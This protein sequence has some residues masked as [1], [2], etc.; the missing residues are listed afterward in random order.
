MKTILFI[1]ARYPGYGG[2]E[3]ITTL[4]ANRLSNKF[5]IIICSIT[6]Q[7]EK[8]LL[9]KLDNK[10]LFLKFPNSSIKKS[11]VNIAYLNKLII[12]RSINYII[13][14]DSYFPSQYLL[15]GI[16]K[17]DSL[18][19]IVVEHSS[20]NGFDIQ[21]RINRKNCSVWDLYH[22]F[23]LWLY[24][25]KSLFN[26]FKNRRL[27]YTVCDKYVMLSDSLIP[28]CKKYG[29]F[30]DEKKFITIGNP[31]MFED[32]LV[33]LSSK[34][35]EC[36]FVGRFDV[37]KGID[38]LIRVW[39][40]VEERID[41]WT[42][43]VVGD[44]DMMPAIR[45]MVYQYKLQN[46]RFEGFQTNVVQYYKRAQIICLCSTFEGFPLVLPEAMGY[47]LVP[48]AFNS[49]PALS[50]IVSDD[51]EGYNIEPFNEELYANKLISLIVNDKKRE[52]MQNNSLKKAQMFSIQSILDKWNNL[53]DNLS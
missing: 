44:G 52:N 8:L 3:N 40:K 21:Y 15:K 31:K 35:K 41:D 17:R 13:Y 20:P 29:H 47:G 4:L 9:S 36:L 7:D 33:G 25:N 32:E 49:F 16:N 50:D 23:K 34:R 14:Q 38:R 30:N 18:K 39:K 53:L 11:Q 24:Y 5:K 2:I 48:I 22:R 12:E 46:I 10:V 19:I 6:Q 43:V 26:E 42:L 37:L 51:I 1:L 45:K 27:L 28:L